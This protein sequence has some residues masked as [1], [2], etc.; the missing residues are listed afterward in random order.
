MFYIVPKTLAIH[1]ITISSLGTVI[2]ELSEAKK[3]LENQNLFLLKNMN[4][5]KLRTIQCS[6]VRFKQDGT[7]ISTIQIGQL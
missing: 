4:D 1:H 5:Q 7:Y 3:C 6:V 2:V